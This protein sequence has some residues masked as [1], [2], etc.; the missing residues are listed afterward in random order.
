[1]IG[2]R[3]NT[4][5]GTSQRSLRADSRADEKEI[6]TDFLGI[7][8]EI[9]NPA[10]VHYGSYETV[11]LKRMRNRYGDLSKSFSLDS[12]IKSAVNLLSLVF[13][14]IYFPTYSDL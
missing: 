6:W 11:F 7:L 9:E 4:A 12:A 2:L 10:L 14:Q 1:V 8:S 3:F 5:Q 13:A